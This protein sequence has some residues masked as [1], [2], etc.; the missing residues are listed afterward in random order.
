M[1]NKELVAATEQMYAPIHQEFPTF[2]E[3]FFYAFKYS[4]VM[5]GHVNSRKPFSRLRKSIRSRNAYRRNYI[6]NP[7]SPPHHYKGLI[8]LNDFRGRFAD[9]KASVV[10][11]T[12]SRGLKL[13]RNVVNSKLGWQGKREILFGQ[14]FSFEHLAFSTLRLEQ[15][16]S[17]F[18]LD[19]LVP[20]NLED[21]ETIAEIETILEAEIS[22]LAKELTKKRVK[23]IFLHDD[24]RPAPAL[25]C[26]A[27][28]QAG[29]K[30]ITIVHGYMGW[31][32]AYSSTLPLNSDHLIVWSDLEADQIHDLYPEYRNRVHSFGFP[33][34]EKPMDELRLA[35]PPEDSKVVAYM[36]GPI[37]FM[38]ERFGEDFFE[39]LWSVRRSVEAAGYSFL[40]RLHW[41]DRVRSSNDGLS[42]V[43]EEFEVSDTS[44]HEDFRR[45]S[46][47]VA[48]YVSSTLIE[49][50]AYGRRAI[51]ITMGEEDPSWGDSVALSDLTEFL[52]N[53]EES[54]VR[55]DNSFRK[56]EFENLV[57][58]LLA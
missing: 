24:Q 35:P 9:L 33:G 36:C 50:S 17:S 41:Q 56:E 39:M 38:K 53:I 54:P 30:T 15:L 43:I 21:L 16:L 55:S 5:V 7:L 32:N 20:R 58:D 4:A 19:G 6:Y 51:N 31:S 26:A 29:V 13:V 49:A 34:L 52:K 8:E 42:R 40:L 46:I 18:A 22:W 10:H 57:F 28:R 23:A 47:V 3:I 48:S 45:S 44:L 37:W 27:A 2:F 14:T 12:K 11:C 25:L 1:N